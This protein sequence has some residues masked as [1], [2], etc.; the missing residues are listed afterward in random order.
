MLT[1]DTILKD[2]LWVGKF[3]DGGRIS[4]THDELYPM[5]EY[6]RDFDIACTENQPEHLKEF[7]RSYFNQREYYIIQDYYNNVYVKEEDN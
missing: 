2:T 6:F 4:G 3:Y 5:N 7:Y 1:L